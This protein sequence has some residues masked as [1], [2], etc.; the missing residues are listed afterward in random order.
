MADLTPDYHK[1]DCSLPL[2]CKDLLDV[3]N[4]PPDPSGES[5]PITE[6][7]AK[8]KTIEIADEITVK[9]LAALLG[10]P[11]H[12]VIETLVTLKVFV[13]NADTRLLFDVAAQV[14]HLHGVQVRRGN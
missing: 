4:L 6:D 10:C 11:P 14:A 1:R 12:M 7:M 9:K 13:P 2:G 5:L 8:P 3:L